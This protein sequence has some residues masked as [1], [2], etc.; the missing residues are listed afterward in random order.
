MRRAYTVLR[1]LLFA[2]EP[3]QAHAAVLT[4]LAALQRSPAALRQLRNQAAPLAPELAVNALGLTF[5]N[6]IGLAAGF[7]KNARVVA[8]LGAMGFGSVEVG[9]VTAA[10]L[11]GNARPRIRRHAHRE[12]VV[13]WM[14]LP[15]EGAEAVAHRLERLRK[16]GGIGSRR[17]SLPPV[18]LNVAGAV[19]EDYLHVLRCCGPYVDY[20]TLNVSCPNVPA[21]RQ[22]SDPSAIR[23]LLAAIH[24]DRT[25]GSLPV[26][27]K[28]GPDLDDDDLEQLAELALEGGA[29]G[30]VATN[31]SATLARGLEPQGGVSGAPL[32]ERSTAVLRRLRA[33][34]GERLTLIGVGGIF[35]AEHA[36][37]KILAG[38]TLL[39]VYTG[40]VYRGPALLAELFTELPRLLAERGYRTLMDAVGAERSG[41]PAAP[42]ASTT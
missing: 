1:P 3:E 24:A 17:G 20:A 42:T 22:L 10:S 4:G 35:T 33:V 29:E 28:I 37:E 26:L 12:A 38:A 40:F 8:A 25:L 16:E 21:G 5:A 6:P 18:G 39:Q 34:G 32:R 23:D 36:L 15:N 9:G 11:S 7:D 41:R 30:M 14:G 31:T 27:L 2:L 19:V 13:N